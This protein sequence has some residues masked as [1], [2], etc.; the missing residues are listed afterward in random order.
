[1]LDEAAHGTFLEVQLLCQRLLRYRS[2]GGERQQREHLRER[3]I[4][5]RR[6]LVGPVQPERLEKLA[7]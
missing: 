5:A 4:K 2:P 1:V 7:K 6:H 3:E